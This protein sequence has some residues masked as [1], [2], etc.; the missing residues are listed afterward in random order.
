MNEN[1]ERGSMKEHPFGDDTGTSTRVPGVEDAG[2]VPGGTDGGMAEKIL[3]NRASKVSGED[4]DRLKNTL[5]EKI[6][7]LKDLEDGLFWVGTLL[8]RVKLLWSMIRDGEFKVS[9]PTMLMV[10]AG[11]IYFVM[12]VDFTPDFIPGIGYIDDAVVLSTLWGLV[13]SE[14][15]EYVLFLKQSGRPIDDLDALAFADGPP[16]EQGEVDL[17]G[18]NEKRA[19]T[20]R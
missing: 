10:A 16:S 8:G 11:L 17:S 3:K 20:A 1:T 5:Q 14:L 6:T 7:G 18:L 13:Q 4:I 19:Q 2:D 9:V 12:P 15:E